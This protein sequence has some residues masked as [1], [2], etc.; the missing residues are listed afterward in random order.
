MTDYV[1]RED[2]VS[3]G[4]TA[5]TDL[6]GDADPG[7]IQCPTSHIGQL[8][9]AGVARGDAEAFV[10]V[11]AVRFTG[12]AVTGNPVIALG[13]YGCGASGTGT[14][15]T[16][17]MDPLVLNVDIPVAAGRNLVMQGLVAGTAGDDVVMSVTAVF[18]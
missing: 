8:I 16:V 12:D 13:A 18:N 5:L 4:A 1:T 9:Y 3:V 11:A 6:Y 10:L 2:I 15:G 17:S 14:S 7:V